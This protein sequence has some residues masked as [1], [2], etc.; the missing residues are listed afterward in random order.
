MKNCIQFENYDASDVSIAIIL[1]ARSLAG[2]LN[3]VSQCMKLLEQYYFEEWAESSIPGYLLDIKDGALIKTI[4]L[5]KDND[6]LFMPQDIRTFKETLLIFHEGAA[7]SS[8][9]PASRDTHTMVMST[10]V[11][12]RGLSLSDSKKNTLMFQKFQSPEQTSFEHEVK[13]ITKSDQSSSD[14][15]ENLRSEP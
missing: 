10:P 2:V 4:G 15:H 14:E 7:P 9:S 8:P 6:N 3:G 5:I 13:V 1:C 12:P 11:Q